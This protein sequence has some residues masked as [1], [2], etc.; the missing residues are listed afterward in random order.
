MTP[1]VPRR[2]LLVDDDALVLGIAGDLLHIGGY[3]VQLLAYPTLTVPTAQQ[4]KPDLIIL[5]VNMPVL[6]GREVQ[7][8]LKSFV[9]TQK[10]PVIF[11]S[12]PMQPR[13]Q[14]RAFSNGALDIWAKPFDPEHVDRLAEIFDQLDQLKAQPPATD[15]DRLR[16]NVLAFY[17]REKLS[18]SLVVNPYT[19][20][21]GRAIFKEGRL[22][23]AHLGPLSD[24][25]A[26]DEMLSLTD[27]V[28]R[29]EAGALEPP[30]PVPAVAAAPTGYKARVLLV[31]DDPALRKLYG[32]QLQRSGFEVVSAD[33]GED[34]HRLATESAFD[35]MVADLNMPVLD[36][37]GMLKLLKGSPRT[38]ELPVLVLSAHD[39]Y[40]ET[41]K[42]ARAGAHDYLRKTGHADE[43]IKRVRA[44][45]APRA[46]VWEA[47]RA[48]QALKRF[49]IGGVGAQW[50]LRTLGEHDCS[51]T[52]E[53][54]DDWGTYRVKCDRGHLLEATAEA[55]AKKVVGLHAVS[56]LI[57]SRGAQATFAPAA[58]G[59][60][61][62]TGPWLVEVVEEACAHVTRLE[63][64]IV[65]ERLKRAT[66]FTVDNELAALFER[67]GSDAD[68][69]IL[70]AISE[71]EV[72]AATLASHLELP[73]ET[74][75]AGL[76]ELVRRGVVR[77]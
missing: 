40:R 29:F 20:F 66:R 38:R 68:L 36:G 54:T 50:L 39:D 5:D 44:L 59:E 57:V 14:L 56:A 70:R 13:E 67:I 62:A 15:A 31:D 58:P 26:F 3:A 51:G 61:E 4:F 25:P 27:G 30:A 32:L 2:I 76:M 23:F 48:G 8:S 21:E 35:M 65:D 37:W 52:L 34:G 71:E 74:I 64:R 75:D 49:E 10:L 69:R 33:H 42:A 47:M 53:A 73:Q 19:P 72:A 63:Q 17:A 28:W 9:A 24:V 22:T 11:L 45:A 7:T 46:L 12:S 41:L 1:N 18:G 43:L 55:G 77:L 60:A 6:S 16:Q